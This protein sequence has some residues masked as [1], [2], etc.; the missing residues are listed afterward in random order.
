M[1]FNFLTQKKDNMKN[2]KFS[3]VLLLLLGVLLA[4]SCSEEKEVFPETRLF[5]PVLNSN[6]AAKDN[7]ILIDMAK[8][9]EAVSYKV[10]ISRDKFTTVLRTI[11]TTENK[12]VIAD[13]LWNTEYQ[14][15]STAIASKPE[16]DSKISD[17][18]SVTTDRFPSIMQIPT[19]SD[20]IDNAAKVHW[21]TGTGTGAAITQVKV[22]AITDEEL[23][24]PLATYAVTT[25]EQTA[26][27]KI[28]GN[29]L[30][31]TEYQLAIYSGETLRGWEKY[32][33]KDPLV[34]GSNVIDLRGILNDPDILVKTMKTAADGSI[35]LL[36]GSVIYN[37][38]DGTANFAFNK[39]L[40]IQS[41]Y[42]F[43][44]AGATL[45]FSKEFAVTAGSNITSIL[46]EGITLT[47]IYTSNYVFNIDAAATIGEIKFNNCKINNFRGVVRAKGVSGGTSGTL[48][49]FTVDNCI[50]NDIKDYGILNMDVATWKF[51]D[52]VIKS[53]TIYRTVLFLVSKSN[54]N[55]VL[56]EDC[57]INESPE[58]ARAIFNWSGAAGQNNVANGITIKNT[59]IG[60]GWDTAAG[61]VDYAIKG[62]TGLATT[63]F[64]VSNSYSTADFK[65]TV[66]GTPIPTFP[67]FTYSKTVTDLWKDPAKGDFNIKDP[68]FAGIKSAGDPRWRK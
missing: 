46:F 14:V 57:T 40:T 42:S 18:G 58:K 25:A 28:I 21:L 53:S 27:E 13:L 66:T 17:L 26:G 16:F 4:F 48:S 30:P 51:T 3:K 68:S 9:K 39:S 23:K 44:P 67:N 63:N 32:K 61:G 47:G 5:R 50:I 31:S 62:I 34:S 43:N 49:K 6:L 36:D 37:T 10:E 24:T 8:M 11:E 22:F 52:A 7:A 29:L 12:I 56:I 60:H 20:V 64:M 54:S 15:R 41:G 59:I 2:I 19:A 55:S 45:N 65:Y 33:T 35:I 1:V 38:N